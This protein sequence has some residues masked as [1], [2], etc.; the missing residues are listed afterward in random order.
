MASG[1]VSRATMPR[2]SSGTALRLKQ[3]D[4]DGMNSLAYKYR[5]SDPPLQNTEQALVWFRR[6]AD[7]EYPSALN[8][9][10]IIYLEGSLVPPDPVQAVELF[11][12]RRSKGTHLRCTTSPT[13]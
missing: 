7:L 9:L 12:A 5:Y 1:L 4:P 8:N 3:G 6:A 13:C 11:G 10:G 2:P